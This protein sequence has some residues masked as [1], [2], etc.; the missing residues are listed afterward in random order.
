MDNPIISALK[1]DT[2][3]VK[4][5]KEDITTSRWAMCRARQELRNQ[6][7]CKDNDHAAQFHKKHCGATIISGAGADA[8]RTISF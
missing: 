6:E 2:F 4:L 1:K 3:E 8:V 7:I 5:A